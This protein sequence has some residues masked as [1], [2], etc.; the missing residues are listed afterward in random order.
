MDAMRRLLLLVGAIVLV[1]TMFF[2]AIAPVLPTYAE[3]F[4]LS[5]TGA[6]VLAGAYAAG[7]VLGT[8][9]SGWLATRLGSRR[10]ALIGLAL[11]GT[12]S[13][14]FAFGHVIVLLDAMRLL[15]GLGGACAWVGG[16]GWLV[17]L[18]PREQRGATIGSAMGAALAGVL[19]GPVLGS[20]ANET[21]PEVPFTVVGAFSG[22]LALA[23]TRMPAPAGVVASERPIAAV[24]GERRVVAGA[25]LVL[26]GS[27]IFGT[28]E[29]L[30]PLALDRLGASGLAIGATFLLA[31]AVEGVVQ[32]GS[33]HVSDRLGRAVPIRFGL[34]G[35]LVVLLLLP[36]PHLAWLLAVL[37]AVGSVLNGT[38]NTPA[39]ALLSDG[40][41]R[42]GIDYGLG[43]A[44]VNLVWGSGQVIG[45]AG[46]GALAS[47]TSDTFTYLMLAAICATTLAGVVRGT[48]REPALAGH[49][50]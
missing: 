4:D 49:A 37:V 18:A 20:I 43:F 45:S 10:T 23:A 50:A 44:I 16:M 47:L 8:L 34:A 28:I 48:R 46:G 19:L 11:M 13:V 42:V 12:S 31:A 6:G 21:G 7:T 33:G 2:A 25:L 30:A 3:R 35:T 29:V 26:V 36:L 38:A 22:L 27:L 40:V 32:V 24:L 15:S 41:E 9:P 1:D 17:S 5:K 39:M 14:G